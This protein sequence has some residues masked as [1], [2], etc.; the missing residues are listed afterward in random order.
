MREREGESKRKSDRER[1]SESERAPESTWEM[2][3]D[4][5]VAGLRW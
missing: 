5:W 1:K 2:G 4:R 3:G